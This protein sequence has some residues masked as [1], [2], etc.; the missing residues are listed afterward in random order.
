MFLHFFPMSLP[1]PDLY[2]HGPTPF[3]HTEMQLFSESFATF[4]TTSPDRY[5][6]S[7]TTIETT[8][9][10]LSTVINLDRAIQQSPRPILSLLALAAH[11]SIPNYAWSKQKV[12]V[13]ISDWKTTRSISDL[14]PEDS[15]HM[16]K[17]RGIVTKIGRI[18]QIPLQGTVRCGKCGKTFDI[19]P[20]CPDCKNTH[21]YISDKHP[22]VIFKQRIEITEIRGHSTLACQLSGDLVD[23]A[24]PGDI[25]DL[26][27]VL[28]IENDPKDDRK[29]VFVLDTNF[30][31]QLSQTKSGIVNSFL[32]GGDV[33]LIRAISGRPFLFPVLVNSILPRAS[34]NPITRAA[35]CLLL[36]STYQD[37][38]HVTL[39]QK[40]GDVRDLAELAP[41]AVVFDEG[42]P[43][44]L[45]C[46]RKKDGI[47]A[48][49]FSRANSG[50]LIVT[51]VDRFL[52]AQLTFLEVIETCKERLDA[53]H[54]IETV[55][56]SIVVVGSP[57]ALEGSLA[58]RFAMRLVAEPDSRQV[59]HSTPRPSPRAGMEQW[60]N[61]YLPIAQRLRG[62]TDIIP[63]HEF[64]KY[65]A[66][67]RQFVHPTWTAGARERL[68]EVAK[69]VPEMR[70]IKNLAQCRARCELRENV[71]D[72]DVDE[73]AELMMGS[74]E[75][76]SRRVGAVRANSRQKI[77]GDFM[78]EFKRAAKYKEGGVIGVAE[79]PQLAEMV[80]YQAKF[81]SFEHFL[82]MLS[83]NNL[84]LQSGP[85]LYR[86][87][88]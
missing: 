56:S 2:L 52:A 24:R 32:S 58:D 28:L 8:L 14:K 72:T 67:A 73:V 64:L 41:R 19:A 65:V 68:R 10:A 15:N 62:V 55:F 81:P 38:V 6:V 16:R 44:S 80:Q 34:L 51:D 82:E 18:D 83:T 48:G 29:L 45:R 63:K 23:S 21:V 76:E 31:K 30:V 39:S 75:T 35:F 77:I 49:A 11:H 74:G 59:P 5:S 20:R 22:T 1:D 50:L 36:F 88:S 71:V 12:I 7:G 70:K 61:Q 78:V 40:F 86:A 3:S 17:I 79:M 26:T 69:S 54:V 4:F 47:T 25:V 37:P 60:Q 43:N 87:G 33:A 46:Q 66:Y 9:A 57:E 53:F 27:G 13:Q 85:R 84:V 42:S